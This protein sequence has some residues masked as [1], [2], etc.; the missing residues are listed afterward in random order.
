MT[1][2]ALIVLNVIL[3]IFF[4]IAAGVLLQRKFTLNLNTLS[5]LTTY[6]LL[7]CVG[8]VNIYE[9]RIQ[10]TILLSILGFLLL[11][12]ACLIA[13]STG[14]AKAAKFD[15]SLSSVFKNSFVLSNSGNFGLPV[16]QLVFYQNPLG[17]SIQIVVTIFQ[18]LLTYTYGLMNSVSVQ[19]NRTKAVGELLKNPMI[20]ALLLG[21]LLNAAKIDI[22]AFLWTPIEN[23]SNA[24]LAVAL[25]TL[26]A[27][28]AY[29]KIGRFSLPL[30]LSL[31]GRL[32]F[33]PLIA[34][35]LILS[36]QLEGTTAQA[37]LIAS[38]FPTSR[39]SALFALEYGNHPEYA[40]QAVFMS[41]IFSSLTVTV[42][43]Y[44]SKMLF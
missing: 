16:S 2:L 31:S 37:L 1:L 35:F 21:L 14:M 36:L 33:S 32:I 43:V 41:T 27:Q 26:G 29:L 40:A 44:G 6:F 39:N 18:N 30:V 38:S 24:F 28:S 3:P 42:V 20:Y 11:Q 22:P 19:S 8:F 13:L 23:S 34:L 5:K 10:G 12:S 15:H 25:V 7:P 17:L 9:S 4:L